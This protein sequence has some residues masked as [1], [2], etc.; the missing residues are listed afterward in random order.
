ML[1]AETSPVLAEKFPS[2]PGYKQIRVLV[3]PKM[4]TINK[5]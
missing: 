3:H 2:L 5:D 4:Q 1:V